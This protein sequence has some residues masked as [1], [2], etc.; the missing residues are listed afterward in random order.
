M[1]LKK[2]QQEAS[3]GSRV[4]SQVPKM[5][6]P[7]CLFPDNSMHNNNTTRGLIKSVCVRVMRTDTALQFVTR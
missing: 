1:F 2:R 3:S 7:L 6:K 5:Q 4:I